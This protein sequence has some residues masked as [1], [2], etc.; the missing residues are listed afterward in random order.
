ME[1]LALI[2]ER[3][4]SPPFNMGFAN[5]AEVDTKTSM[6]LLNLLT[7]VVIAIDPDQESLRKEDPEDRVSRIIGFLRVMKF[8][9]PD[10]QIDDFTSL[11]MNGDKE[12]LFSVMHWCLQR[13]DQLKKRAYLAKYLLP[14]DIPADFQGEDLINELLQNMKQL[15]NDFK[16]I[17]KN[18]DQLRADGSRPAELR[19][20]ILQLEQE[21]TQLQ[22]KIMRLTKETQEDEPYFK[23]ML[24]VTLRNRLL[25]IICFRRQALSGRS[26]KR[27][28]RTSTSSVS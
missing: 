18:V 13:F 20:E 23:E 8:T 5:L 9:L 1:K 4:N 11:M 15:Q 21:R 10:D 2:V 27:R 24:K 19:N 7:D 12:V 26:R 6:Q 22:N 17:H 3:L 14:I 16:D 25:Q 28:P